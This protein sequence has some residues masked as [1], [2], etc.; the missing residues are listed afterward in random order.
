MEIIVISVAAYR[1]KDAVVNAITNGKSF[2]FYAKGILSNKN[3]NSFLNCALCKADITLIEG[4]IKYP[5][6]ETAELIFSPMEKQNYEV[7]NCALMMN[8]AVL[9]LFPEDERFLAY[10]ALSASLIALKSG[11]N[12]F[13]VALYFL[14]NILP[15]LGY[16]LEVKNCVMC[17]SKSDIVDF[18]FIEG[19][20]L[21]KKCAEIKERRYSN[22]Q[23]LLI[24]GNILTPKPVNK[25]ASLDEIK[26]LLVDINNF[27]EEA[28]VSRLKYLDF[29]LK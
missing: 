24:R 25:D 12:S 2:S 13:L 22:S 4:K 18:S 23:L 5:I 10:D 19:G 6:L 14:L 29:L 21:C 17:G 16:E 9:K 27:I 26:A 11:E 8:E 28:S 20:F 3:K 1:E 15:H 7:L